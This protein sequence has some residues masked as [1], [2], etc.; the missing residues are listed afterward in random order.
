M[1][2]LDTGAG[3]IAPPETIR[4]FLVDDHELVRRGLCDVLAAARDILVVGEAAT[5]ADAVP[6]V[7]RLLPDV[8]LLDVRLPDGSGVDVCRQVRARAPSVRFL[9]LTSYDDRETLVSSLRAG[10]S[11]FALKQIRGAAL[12]DAVRGVAEGRAVTN[13]VLAGEAAPDDPAAREVDQILAT[14][15]GQERR[16]LEGI[17]NG[18]TNREIGTE[19]GIAE[20]TVKNHVTRLLAKLGVRYR[21]QAAVLGA[22]ARHRGTWGRP[23]FGGEAAGGRR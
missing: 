14:L 6:E 5:A 1:T 21:T 20:Q 13:P 22:E 9:V 3:P 23:P 18:L 10:A 2:D 17:V 11:G 7:L 15:T 8:V 19:L 4:V 12:I 16:I